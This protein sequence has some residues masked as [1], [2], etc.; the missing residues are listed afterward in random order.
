M[1]SKRLGLSA[2]VGIL[3]LVAAAP[4]FAQKSKDVLRVA[5]HQPIRVVDAVFNPHPETLLMTRMVF[6]TLVYFDAGARKFEPG[7]AKSWKRLDDK[8]MEFKLRDDVK[9]HD[10]SAFDADDVLYTFNFVTDPNVNFR[11]KGNRYGWIK[12]VEKIDQY[13][14]RITSK[15]VY[16]PML[17]RLSN[18]PPIY[19]SSVH[20]K[21]EKK[22]TFG[23][24]PV[25]T[26]PYK[27]TR[28]DTKR[29]VVFE[30]N[31]DYAR[32][33]MAKPAG[34]IRRIEISSIPD[35]QTQVAKLLAGELDLVYNVGKDLG[36]SLKADPRM[37][38]STQRT[39]SFTYFY[40]DV[41]DR[42]GIG[43]FK[44]KRVRKAL[45]HAVDR[46]ALAKAFLPASMHD[47]TLQ[48]GMCHRWH[49][50]CDSSAA[51]P[52]HDLALA[53][54]LLAEAGYADGFDLAL[55]TW[56][57]STKIAEAVAGQLRRVGIRAKVDAGTIGVFVKKRAQGKV[58][59]F[60]SLWDNGVAQP[61][62]D[63]T[64]SFFFMPSSRNYTADKQLAKAVMDGRATFDVAERKAIYRKAFD[65]VTN[66][67]YMMPLI[68]LP[69]IVVNHKDV[70]LHGGHKSPEGFEFN[71]IS[72]K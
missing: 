11:F 23:R 1:I 54:K 2:T 47:D 35:N 40:F 55:T 51:P 33:G 46:T 13:T 49:I 30:R 48:Q 56:G 9:Y 27:V 52:K 21:L 18:T 12:K 59:T 41:A 37:E 70:K 14:V 3:A 17:S 45:M 61:D 22:N 72:W 28:V 39:V 63:T 53:K 7:L 8:T 38:L 44:D 15:A 42:S 16:A 24:A 25:G 62:V 5:L 20:G 4:A 69:A 31:E 58:Q 36:E 65:R 50:A 32:R 68:P 66:E 26:G 43:V 71:R 60:V 34:K 64:M 6:D 10:G 29:G 67:H 57:A 19:P